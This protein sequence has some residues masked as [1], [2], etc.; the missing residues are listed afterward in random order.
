MED[1]RT[2]LARAGF[3]TCGLLSGLRVEIE[4]DLGYGLLMSLGRDPTPVEL[5]DLDAVVKEA[6]AKAQVE[7]RR[8]AQ[9]SDMEMWSRGRDVLKRPRSPCPQ[10]PPRLGCAPMARW[11]RTRPGGGMAAVVA[12]DDCARKDALRSR[13]LG[14]VAGFV[15]EAGLPAAARLREG[16]PGGNFLGLGR[17]LRYSTIQGYL[18]TWDRARS[19][20]QMACGVPWP[21]ESSEVAALLQAFADSGCGAATLQR[22]VHALSYLEMAGEVPE[23]CMM[24][25][26]PSV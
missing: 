25:R 20:L 19:W 2:T 9:R 14:R 23:H 1:L 13:A 16:I 26:A 8:I 22:F 5:G 11:P 4:E 17:G 18:R 12:V 10:V 15:V 7:H 21:R 24:A 3:V 6:E